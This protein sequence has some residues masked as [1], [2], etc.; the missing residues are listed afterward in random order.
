MCQIL[1]YHGANRVICPAIFLQLSS[2]VS[3]ANV[4]ASPIGQARRCISLDGF[5]WLNDL[6]LWTDLTFRPFVSFGI[7][8]IRI[9]GVSGKDPQ[10]SLYIGINI[11][12]APQNGIH[13][14]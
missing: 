2:G 8:A 6:C 11:D 7:N 14:K 1:G 3:D 10:T 13:I 9:V 5:K 12:C 4:G